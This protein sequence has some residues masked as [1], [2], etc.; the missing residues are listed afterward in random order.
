VGLGSYFLVELGLAMTCS[1][2]PA[3]EFFPPNASGVLHRFG[4]IFFKLRQ[5]WLSL[6]TDAAVGAYICGIIEAVEIC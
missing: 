2:C 6:P 3:S 4:W 5:W 1:K